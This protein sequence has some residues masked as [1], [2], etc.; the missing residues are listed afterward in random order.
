M[1]ETI[2]WIVAANQLNTC[3]LGTSWHLALPHTS[4]LVLFPEHLQNFDRKKRFVFSVIIW[5]RW[6]KLPRIRSALLPCRVFRNAA[7][8]S[9]T[10]PKLRS[11][12]GG[13]RTGLMMP[14]VHEFCVCVQCVCASGMPVAPG[15]MTYKF[16]VT[17]LY[18]KGS[19]NVFFF[20]FCVFGEFHVLSMFLAV[21]SI[22]Q[23]EWAG[24]CHF[25]GIC[26]IVRTSHFLWYCNSLVLFTAFWSWKL[27]FINDICSIFEFELFIFHGICNMLVLEL[28]M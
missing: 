23:L 19:G 28:F 14:H 4:G 13:K 11:T 21:C 5:F 6:Q 8:G 27:P 2:N 20:P 7:D 25:N 17:S 22:L 9:G 15:P 16:L 12:S 1:G 3:S 24:S 18:L 26:N 10:L